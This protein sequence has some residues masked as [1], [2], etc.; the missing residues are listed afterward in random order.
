[1]IIQHLFAKDINRPINGVVQVSDDRAIGQELDEYVVT[2]ELR[3]HFADFF[4]A[5][6][7]ALDKPTD[8]VGVWISGYFGSG[9]SHF[10]KMLSYLL[11]NPEVGG[12]RA[13][14]YFEGKVDDPMVMEQMR[15]AASVETEAI[16]FNIDDMGGGWK[17]GAYSETALLRTFARV[18]YEHLGFFGLD[19]KLARFEKMVD[20]RGGT[21]RFREAYERIAGVPWVEERD[22]YGFHSMEIAEAAEEALGLSASDV[23]SWID[24]EVEIALSPVD[25][26]ADIKEYVERRKSECGGRF[27]LLFM[28]DEM[29]QFIGSNVSRMLNLQTIVEG[30]GTQCQ[31]DAWV[32]VTSQEALDEMRTIVENDFSKI[33][34]RFATRLSLSSSSADEVIKRR[35]LAKDATPANE[36]RAV[37]EANSAVLKNLFSLEQAAGNLV[38]YTGAKDFV[39]TYPFVGYQF[40]LMPDVLNQIRKHGYSGKH[41]ST[42]ERSMLS[43]FQESAQAVE[44]N[45]VGALVPFWRLFDTLERQLDHGIK[46][47]FERARRQAELGQGLEGFDVQVLKALYLVVY[48]PDTQLPTTVANVAILMA[49]SIGADTLA[50][51]GKVQAALER[52][53]TQNY[54]TRDGQR[55]TFLTDQE[56]D[57]EREIQATQIDSSDVLERIKQ[58]VY[59]GI[60][61]SN[62]LRKGA[63][64]FPVDR[65]VDD[66]I[67]GR[68]QNGMR[69]NLLT[70]S[71]ELAE[72]SDIELGMRS[73]GQALVA[74][75]ADGDYYGLVQGAAKVRKYV[76]G[77][78][79]EGLPE[80]KRAFVERKQRQANEDVKAAR[81]VLEDAIVHARVA[82][83]GQVVSISATTAK[84][85]LDAVLERLAGAVFTKAELVGAPLAGD[86]QLGEALAGQQSFA[87][88]DSPNAP[89]CAEML[90]YLEAQDR[91]HQQ[92]SFG[93]LQR[94]FQER[95]YG[96]RQDD[97]SLV[98]ATLVGQQR[99]GVAYAGAAVAARDPKLRG[100]LTNQSN[101]DKLGVKVRRSV[102]A[103]LVSGA[104]AL[105]RDLDPMAQVPSDEDGLVSA[106]ADALGRVGDRC[107]SLERRYQSGRAY[108]G[109]GEV[110]KV[111]AAVDGLLGGSRD[112]E[113]FLRAATI[114]ADDLADGLEDMGAVEQFF[115]S[116]SQIFDQAADAVRRLGSERTYF[117]GDPA[118][119]KALGDINAILTLERPYGRVHEL[120]DLRKAAEAAYDAVVREMREKKLEQLS[121]TVAEVEAYCESQKAKASTEI[122]TIARDARI[123]EKDKRLAIEHE[124]SCTRLDAIGSQVSAWAGQQYRKVDEAV[125][126]A[127]QAKIDITGAKVTVPPTPQPRTKV[128]SRVTVC[129]TKLLDSEEAVDAYVASIRDKLMDALRESGSVRLG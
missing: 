61:T 25:L 47:V 116:Q 1:M 86:A 122:G 51:K 89:A 57:V 91:T 53:V 8:R 113:A 115:K 28:A 18:F 128:L 83:D 112:P 21:Q 34:G 15:R 111:R 107:A 109:E 11:E 52:L 76:Q 80:E 46:Q 54:V 67:H 102:P 125:R 85:K 127:A 68:L 59:D 23:E 30:L 123:Y 81:T 29:G 63:N 9:K 35:V 87:G 58:I 49:D 92:V 88:V 75:A 96:W 48:L 90:R 60:Y 10:L 44:K 64:D 39:E 94:H 65:Y 56:Q 43:A 17:E 98:L 79:R 77:I 99:A 82:V 27:R 106:V 74:L 104:K 14:D 114:A 32:M 7:D 40:A 69:L 12:R 55:Y 129:P 105:L 62:K 19:L 70:V 22:A 4:G 3:R 100:M 33:Q 121:A 126:K 101:F 108:P 110:R 37:Y 66:S 71:H 119:T 24:N 97:V 5:Y 26:V 31:G 124:G 13:I 93:D 72:A 6:E 95:P 42:G 16:L 2:R 117:E 45:E 84:N 120:T 20:D 118:V 73:A 78:N 50:L 41:I 103:H 38:G 36:L